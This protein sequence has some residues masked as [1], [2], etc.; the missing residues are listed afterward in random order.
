MWPLE[1]RAT[2]PQ[3]P[4]LCRASLR[5]GPINFPPI[6]NGLVHLVRGDALESIK[7]MEELIEWS[8]KG[9]IKW[10]SEGQMVI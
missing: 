5:E 1:D 2:A 9:R 7:L 6:T 8:S 10:G 4:S 3:P